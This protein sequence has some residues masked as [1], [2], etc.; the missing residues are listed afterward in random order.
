L[1]EVLPLLVERD[2]PVAVT[3]EDNRLEGVVVRG[4]LIGGLTTGTDPDNGDEDLEEEEPDR[5]SSV[6][7]NGEGE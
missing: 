4:S 2:L 7:R 1:R 6:G 5:I 3:N